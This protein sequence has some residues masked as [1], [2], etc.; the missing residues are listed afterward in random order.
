MIENLTKDHRIVLSSAHVT[1]TN[2]C[3]PFL[4]PHILLTPLC[5]FCHFN[6]LIL[7]YVTAN[8]DKLEKYWIF[9]V[10]NVPWATSASAVS[11]KIIIEPVHCYRWYYMEN[12]VL[13]CAHTQVVKDSKVWRII[14]V[15]FHGTELQNFSHQQRSFSHHHVI[16]WV[17][18]QFQLLVILI[19]H[20]LSW[21]FIALGN[22]KSAIS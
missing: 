8:E 2:I 17:L 21:L 6:R 11:A 5:L 9:E 7:Y 1:M 3:C 15:L 20:V 16:I 4:I 12:I 22:P 10:S 19:I 18:V 13:S 14:A